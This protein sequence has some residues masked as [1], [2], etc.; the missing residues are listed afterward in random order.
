MWIHLLRVLEMMQTT[1]FSFE[2]VDHILP[3]FSWNYQCGVFALFCNFDWRNDYVDYGEE[4]MTYYTLD[5][6]EE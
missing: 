2:T 5:G 3:N 4:L 6:E 1:L